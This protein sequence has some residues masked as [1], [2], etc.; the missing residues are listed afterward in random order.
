M[1]RAMTWAVVALWGCGNLAVAQ[2]PAPAREQAG[3]P[4]PTTAP[5]AAVPSGPPVKLAPE[6]I[7]V[8]ERVVILA[9]QTFMLGEQTYAAANG[10]FFGE[11]GCLTEPWKCI[12]GYPADGANFV[13]AT[14]DWSENLSGYTRKFH[15]GPRAT[16][17]EIANATTKPAPDSL[18]SYAYTAAALQPGN[19][20]HGLCADSK[21]RLCVSDDGREPPVRDGFCEPCK[22]LQ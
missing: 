12:P 11:I 10:G 20:L 22:K 18:K 9:L 1:S 7:R 6:V 14:H 5:P 16:T 8:S 3:T 13:D 2:E 21:K 17:A 19:G 4:A 15:A